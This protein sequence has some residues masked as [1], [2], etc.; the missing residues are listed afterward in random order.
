MV[1][2]V[3]VEPTLRKERVFETRTSTVSSRP[4]LNTYTQLRP[5]RKQVFWAGLDLGDLFR[6][7]FLRTWFTDVDR[8]SIEPIL[9]VR[10]VELLDHFD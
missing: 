1:R 2:A 3:G 10:R 5:C 9:D 8:G 6:F 4:R 7:G